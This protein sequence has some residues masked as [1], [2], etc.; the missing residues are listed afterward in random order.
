MLTL[1]ALGGLPPPGRAPAAVVRAQG[2]GG[3]PSA[4]TSTTSTSTTSTST[5]STSTTSTSL[6]TA[7]NPGT[8][9][10]GTGTS[11]P[12]DPSTPVGYVTVALDFIERY[13]LRRTSVDFPAL[14]AKALARAATL[15]TVPDSYPLITAVLRE[16]GD[17][18]ASFSRPPDASNLLVGR[19]TGFGFTATFPDRIV[20]ALA[21]GGPAAK[22][23]LRL[24]DR[25]EKV[26]GKAPAGTGGTL[27]IPREN[28]REATRVVLEVTRPKLTRRLRITIDQ[29]QPTLVSAPK[30]SAGASVAPGRPLA[31]RIGYLDL[32]GVVT[33]QAGLEAWTQSVHDAIRTIDTPARCGW[34]LDLRRNR[35]GYIYPML[36]AVGPLLGE[37]VVAGKRD[38]D[39]VVE[40]WIYRDGAMSVDDRVQATVAVPYRLSR[41]DVPVAVLTSELTASAAEAV[42]IAFTGRPNTRSFGRPTM[43][44]TTFTVMRAMPDNALI[45]VTNAVDIDRAGNGYDGPVRP[46]EAVE[47][48]WATVATA[49]DRAL[50]TAL[51]WLAA[52]RSCRT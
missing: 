33:D 50:V 37:G 3:D 29:G 13:A 43:G 25:I 52:Q 12:P 31:D 10:S 5:A 47:W 20:I 6:A 48:D 17:R 41:A 30:A 40:R 51:S 42:A 45:S 39:G 1:A 32:Q 4:S 21:D 49:Q 27:Y 34:V 18:H 14:R 16:I 23:G 2:D 22:A 8:G 19:Y 35:G 26:N 9:N 44:L 7:G 38:V 15:T 28:G 36:A 24:R 11:A 46:D